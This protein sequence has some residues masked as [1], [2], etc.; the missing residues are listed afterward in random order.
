M[1]KPQGFDRW[2]SYTKYNLRDVYDSYLSRSLPPVQTPLG[3]KLS[4]SSSQHHVAMQAGKFEAH[5][6]ALL[7]RLLTDADAL[8]DVGANVGYFTCIARQMGKRA[9]AIEPLPANLRHLYRNLAINGWSD[10]EVFPMAA[11]TE[12]G[13]LTLHGASSTGASLIDNWAGAPS[14]F[15]RTVAVSTLDRM[16]GAISG[17]LVIKIDVEGHEYRALLGAGSLLDR[18]PRPAWFC[19][20]SLHEFHPSGSNQDFAPTFDL[21]FQRGYKAER[22][23]DGRLVPVTVDDVRRWVRDRNTGVPFFNYLFT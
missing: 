10:T 11:S 15:R 13:Q 16:V 23:E 7:Q 12:P 21:F 14:L 2:W 18:S 4:G 22:L 20:I 6:V 8:I 1:W 3:F 17:K 5:E 9:I 19:E